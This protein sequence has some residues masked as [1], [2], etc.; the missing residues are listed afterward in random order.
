MSV[1]QQHIAQ[2]LG[3]SRM[4]VSLA[5][6][7]SSQVSPET[8]QRVNQAAH[9]LG[10]RP[11][12][13]ARATR[14]GCH[15]AVAVLMS[16]DA[17][18]RSWVLPNTMRS[19]DRRLAESDYHITLA[20]LPD[21]LLTEKHVPKLLREYVADG[22]LIAYSEAMPQ[23]FLDLIGRSGQPAVW[24]NVNRDEDAVYP[25]DRQAGRL[26]TQRLIEA[27]HRRIV[28]CDYSHDMHS[29]ATH[30]SAYERLAGYRDAMAAAM[31]EPIEWIQ[32]L[33][34]G[35][36]RAD[37]TAAYLSRPNRPTAIISYGEVHAILY[38]AARLNLRVPDDLSLVSFGQFSVQGPGVLVDTWIVPQSSLGTAAAEM[39]LARI[40]AP[41]Q[42]L[43]SRAIPF[44]Y[45]IG[46]SVCPVEAS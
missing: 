43:P 42:S 46:N 26:A 19:L 36:D 13:G 25:D 11:N 8:W 23:G 27:G 9:E 17:V 21:Q 2:H 29:Q 45:D 20:H 3:L 28:Y 5:L 33:V 35:T 6:R 31:Y 32:G 24:L 44:R 40:S 10:Y 41:D 18:G 16:A 14:T 39:M 34:P 37:V 1:T 30:Y 15:H 7:G 12:A 22:L 4:A 38:A